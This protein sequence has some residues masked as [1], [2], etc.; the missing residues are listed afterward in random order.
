[1]CFWEYWNGTLYYLDDRFLN[2]HV[3]TVSINFVSNGTCN[4]WCTVCVWG[5]GGGKDSLAS[6][7]PFLISYLIR[8]KVHE[9]ILIAFN[10][11][12][13]DPIDKQDVFI[14]TL[15][16]YTI[17]TNYTVY[18][19]FMLLSCQPRVTVTSCFVYKVIRDLES[20]DHLC[21]NPI[22]R[23]GLIHKRSFDSC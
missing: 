15:N 23:I 20:I 7:S 21:I 3:V 2:S 1:M 10:L 13:H 14:W 11:N 4:V 16:R 9:F 17:I 12:K 18:R 8:T 6:I 5:G 19:H 22:L